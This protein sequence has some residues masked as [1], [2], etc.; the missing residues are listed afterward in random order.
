MRTNVGLCVG[1]RVD[2]K[3]GIRCD[4][5]SR[6]A[7]VTSIHRG[8]SFAVD[9]DHGGFD[10]FPWRCLRNGTVRRVPFQLVMPV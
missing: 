7:V 5:V 10:V 8:S 9:Y 2:V 6:L 3:Y 4:S 1:D